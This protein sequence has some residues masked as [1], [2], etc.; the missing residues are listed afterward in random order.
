MGNF[1]NKKKKKKKR[2]KEN[3]NN[4]FPHFGLP[5]D[6]TQCFRYPKVYQA[7]LLNLLFLKKLCMCRIYKAQHY[8]LH[9]CICTVLISNYASLGQ[10]IVDSFRRARSG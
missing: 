10:A 7:N 4:D 6:L 9:L 3:L 5:A 8:I 2:K 1:M